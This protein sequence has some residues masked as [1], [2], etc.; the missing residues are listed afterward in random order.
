MQIRIAH[1]G[2]PKCGR[3]PAGLDAVQ[4]WSAHE[5]RSKCGCADTQYQ[6]FSRNLKITGST[7]F[8]QGFGSF[9]LKIHWFDLFF[10]GFRIVFK[11]FCCFDDCLSRF[12]ENTLYCVSARP[13]F[14]RISCALPICTVSSP[15]GS[16]PNFARNVWRNVFAL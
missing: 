11:E 3:L 8:F 9:L 4:I 6:V 1:D 12:P 16:R 13:H 15:A 7:C 14:G 5:K 2:R 10:S